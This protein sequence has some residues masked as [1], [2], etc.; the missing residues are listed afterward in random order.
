MACKTKSPVFDSK[1]V[2]FEDF[3]G[4]GTKDG[5]SN[6]C[7][8]GAGIANY[9]AFEAN[10][11]SNKKQRQESEVRSLLDK[12]PPDTIIVN[13][14]EI[15]IIDKANPEVI[16]AEEKEE[17]LEKERKINEKLAKKRKKKEEKKHKK[18]SVHDKKVREKIQDSFREQT[19][20]TFE[21]KIKTAKDIKFLTEATEEILGL[22]KK[23][24]KITETY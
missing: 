15:G 1:F 7:I 24:Q 22:P 21:L 4:V 18:L 6:L 3:L 17:K 12:L 13:P 11:F 9:D 14:H 19:K 2:N 20:D 8:P 16:K 5:F 10:P 23:K